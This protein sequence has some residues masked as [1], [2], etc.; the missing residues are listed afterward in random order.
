MGRKTLVTG[1]LSVGLFALV[2]A[3]DQP[4]SPVTARKKVGPM[5]EAIHADLSRRAAGGFSGAIIVEIDGDVVLDAGYGWADRERR[6]PF[7]TSTIAQTGSLTKQFT[8]AAIVDLSRQRRLRLSDPISKYLLAAYPKIL[9][10]GDGASVTIRALIPQ[11]RAEVGVFFERVPEEDR[12]FLKEEIAAGTFSPHG[13]RNDNARAFARKVGAK[14]WIGMT[15]PKQYGG[16]ERSHL[17][18]AEMAA[19]DPRSV[20]GLASQRQ[21]GTLPQ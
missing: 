21:C 20:A 17:W 14:G 16:H 19:A 4:D 3:A 1:L 2:A 5:A 15:W 12:A 11:D 6:T 18:Q 7:T 8:A 13:G 10:L 9:K